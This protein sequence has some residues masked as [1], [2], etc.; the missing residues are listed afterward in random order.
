MKE[1][2]KELALKCGAW[3]QVYGNTFM[4]DKNF[5][6]AKFYELVVKDC[7]S[8][9]MDTSDRYRKEYFAQKVL[10]LLNEDCN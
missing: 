10:E 5:D 1:R 6:I 3:N 4:V 2:V 8:H 7:A 9:L